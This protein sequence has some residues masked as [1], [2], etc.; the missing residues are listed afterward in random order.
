MIATPEEAR[1]MAQSLVLTLVPHAQV[2]ES[3]IFKP[4]EGHMGPGGPVAVMRQ[5]HA[6]IEGLIDAAGKE[7][8]SPQTMTRLLNAI[9]IAR[10][11]FGKE[12]Q[13]LFPITR[14]ALGAAALEL[15]GRQWADVRKVSLG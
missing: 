6:E 4:L 10:G 2:E 8:A 9:A 5:E 14:Q 1:R 15:A 7:A 11:H 3:L 12:E 13:I